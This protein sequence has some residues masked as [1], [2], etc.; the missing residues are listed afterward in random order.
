MCVRYGCIKIHHRN[1]NQQNAFAN[2]F[3]CARTHTHTHSVPQHVSR[4]A[5]Q[6]IFPFLSSKPRR[7][8]NKNRTHTHRTYIQTCSFL[9]YR[10]Q[11]N[12]NCMC[13]QTPCQCDNFVH[14]LVVRFLTSKSIYDAVNFRCHLVWFLVNNTRYVLP[15]QTKSI[16]SV[17]QN[18]RCHGKCATTNNKKYYELNMSCALHSVQNVFKLNNVE[19]GCA[20]VKIKRRKKWEKR[21]HSKRNNNND[22][23]DEGTNGNGE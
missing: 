22:D 15:V 12:P 19:H 5:R 10:I 20:K 6:M 18:D 7:K 21:T 11:I 17:L 3:M 1:S 13:M 23:D 4:R 14:S 2:A 8:K 9:L 16:S